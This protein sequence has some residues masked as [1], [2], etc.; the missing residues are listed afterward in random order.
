MLGV[1]WLGVFWGVVGCVLGARGARGRRGFGF[2]DFG[3]FENS[4]ENRKSKIGNR[5]FGRAMGGGKGGPGAGLIMGGTTGGHL[6]DRKKT[7][8]FVELINDNIRQS[9]RPEGP[10]RPPR[11]FV[12]CHMCLLSTALKNDSI[13]LPPA[14]ILPMNLHGIFVSF[15]TEPALVQNGNQTSFV[16]FRFRVLFGVWIQDLYFR[17]LPC[18]VV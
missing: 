1:C 13:Y 7:G 8:S 17:L 11:G 3:N 16:L 6:P 14:T 12:C 15:E 9:N 10:T 18:S 5:K 4:E 2:R